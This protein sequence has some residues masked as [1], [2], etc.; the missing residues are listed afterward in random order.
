MTHLH[1]FCVRHTAVLITFVVACKHQ[2][3]LIPS[4]LTVHSKS[5][6]NEEILF[7]ST[8]IVRSNLNTMS[9]FTVCLTPAN[10]KY[11]VCVCVCVCVCEMNITLTLTWLLP[12]VHPSCIH[13]DGNKR[14]DWSR[15]SQTQTH[16]SM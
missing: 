2:T 5:L 12:E 15:L 11:C 4:L 1:H 7:M 3:S 6:I 16:S 14:S 8:Q 9:S 10:R 13:L